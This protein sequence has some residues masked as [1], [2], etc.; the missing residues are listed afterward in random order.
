MLDLETPNRFYDVKD[1]KD[2]NSRRDKIQKYLTIQRFYW[3][4]MI[5]HLKTS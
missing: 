3:Q 4:P 1:L 2:T 5:F